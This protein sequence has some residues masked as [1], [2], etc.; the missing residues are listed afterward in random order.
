MIHDS[1]FRKSFFRSQPILNLL[2]GGWRHPS[3]CACNGIL[4]TCIPSFG[5]QLHLTILYVHCVFCLLAIIICIYLLGHA[6]FPTC[7][8]TYHTFLTFELELV[9]FHLCLLGIAAYFWFS[10]ALLLWDFVPKLQ[11]LFTFIV[12]SMFLLR[13]PI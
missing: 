6:V 3:V 12:G 13:Y 10:M 4:P 7:L 8:C 9:G 5:L 1:S 2:E 11:K